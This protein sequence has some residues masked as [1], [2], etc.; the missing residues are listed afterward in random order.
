LILSPGRIS[1]LLKRPPPFP[2]NGSL[3]T[4]FFL[5]SFPWNLLRYAIRFL[6]IDPVV[7]MISVSAIFPPPRFGGPLLESLY[8]Q[9]VPLGKDY[10]VSLSVFPA[11]A[12]YDFFSAP[13]RSNLSIPEFPEV[14]LSFPEGYRNL[15]TTKRPPPF[16]LFFVEMQKKE[17]LLTGG[18]FFKLLRQTSSL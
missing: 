14:E 17:W 4:R 8:A 6:T 1:S 10:L 12:F 15:H 16:P 11:G 5:V 9:Q 2:S 18:G 13:L 7:R 3:L